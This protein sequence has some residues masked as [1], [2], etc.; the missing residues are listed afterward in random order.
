MATGENW[1]PEENEATVASY[2]S[3]LK[4]ELAGKPFTKT[5]ENA[6]LRE[7]LDGRS[8]GAVEFKFANISAVLAENNMVYIDG[9]KPRRS[10]QQPLRDEVERQLKLHRSELNDLIERLLEAPVDPSAAVK[11]QLKEVDAPANG[12]SP[13]P[14]WTPRGA[15]IKR[16]Y[17]EMDAKN[18]VLGLAGELEVVAYERNRLISLGLKHLAERVKHASVVE[19]D[20]LGYDIQSFGDD[21]TERLIEVKTTKLP[22]ETPFLVSSNEI[23][24]SNYYAERYLLYRIFRFGSKQQGMYRLRGSLSESCDLKPQSFFGAPRSGQRE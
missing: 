10:F 15:G 24:A 6:R 3:M 14:A 22:R 11:G 2:F 23:A 8:K 17:A 13:S 12:L 18:R 16:N 7:R 20:G 21:G 19:G 4:L 5:V 1:S 9:Y